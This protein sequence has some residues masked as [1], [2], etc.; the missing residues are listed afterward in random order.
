ML[1]IHGAWLPGAGLAVWAEDSALPPRAPRRP[2]RAPRERPHPFAA[3]RATLAAALAAGPPAARA[4][5]VLLRLPTRAGSPADSPELV[6]TAVDEPV[7]GPVTLAG[8]RAPALRYA[9]GDALALLR[10]AGDLAG[11]CGATLRHLADVAEFAADLVHRGR[12]LPGVAPAEA[13]APTA[14]R[15]TSRRLPTG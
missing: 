14:F 8:W 6:R 1:V 11:V 3:D 13:P 2:G 15:P 7:R 4:G 12:V 5:S 10:A 9:P